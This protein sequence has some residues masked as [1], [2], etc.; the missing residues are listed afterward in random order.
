M[1]R[2]VEVITTKYEAIAATAASS[3][4]GTMARRMGLK[5]EGGIGFGIGGMGGGFGA[6]SG[7]DDD[8]D[9]VIIGQKQPTDRPTKE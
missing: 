2:G 5:R 1:R 3:D 9:G 8:H 6:V 4:L 7:D